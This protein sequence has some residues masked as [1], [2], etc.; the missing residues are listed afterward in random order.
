MPASESLVQNI[1]RE[2]IE[3]LVSALTAQADQFGMRHPATLA[4]AHRLAIGFWSTGDTQSA[5]RV[6]DQ[7]LD[8]AA[9]AAEPLDL[10]GINALHTLGKILF[11]ERHVEQAYAI[12]R[13][14]LEFHV[15]RCGSTQP[16]TLAAK[17]DLATVLFERGDK[18]E[19]QR[20]RVRRPFPPLS[21]I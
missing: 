3:D 7:I 8:V 6:L 17:G 12:H 10:L 18:E 19:S 14:V 2:N 9:D 20:L 4:A 1:G 21:S 11:E 13:D 15:R 16:D 5:I